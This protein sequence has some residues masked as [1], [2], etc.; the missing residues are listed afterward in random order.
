MLVV[1]HSHFDLVPLDLV[2]FL[3]LLPALVVEA[4]L[5]DVQELI[6]VVD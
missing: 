6:Y 3:F 1:V 2:L 4:L 5:S